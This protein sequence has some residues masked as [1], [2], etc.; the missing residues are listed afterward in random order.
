[1][2]LLF[3]GDL[4]FRGLDGMTAA[5]ARA[6]LCEMQGPLSGADFVIPNLECPLAM[7]DRHAPIRKAGP[8]LICGPENICFL[9][10]MGANA[11]TLANNHTGDYGPG[12]VRETLRLLDGH[13]IAHAGAGER[14]EEAYQPIRLGGDVSVLSVC[15]H[16]FGLADERT[17]G[18][19]GY[20]PRRL[21]R[22]IR[23]E[24]E[25]G[26]RVIVVF[27]GGNEFCPFPS[28]DTVERYRLVCDLGADAVIGGHTH[29]PQGYELYKGKP[30]AYSL[31][32]LLF[33]S[34]TLREARDS[35]HYGYLALLEVGEGI[36]LEAIP[37]RFEP[38]GSRIRLFSGKEKERMLGYIRSLSQPIGDPE[39]LK[40]LFMG[41]AWMHPWCPRL[42]SP[43]EADFNAAGYL[44]LV[45]C[46]AHHS[47]LKTLLQTYFEGCEAQAED[48][49]QRVRAARI[50]P[51]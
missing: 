16:E 5:R 9:E 40:R 36:G 35:W 31:G 23:S 47:Q 11:V 6:I 32:N 4:N 44:D 2:K 28:P 10:A 3:A 15:E 26:R 41:W 49:A 34:S 30:I 45:T 22:A 39:L 37:Y 14:V 38:D 8:N 12:A 25:D 13:G 19:A 50:M 29:C 46:E 21:L 48:W 43:K 1:M 7:E 24:K 17:P 33:R 18:S 42:P 27:H 51:V 20:D